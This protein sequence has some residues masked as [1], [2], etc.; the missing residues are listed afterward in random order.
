M[1]K[2]SG[3][4][5]AVLRRTELDHRLTSA[6]ISAAAPEAARVEHEPGGNPSA[7][8]RG[9][10]RHCAARAGSR[11]SSPSLRRST[12]GIGIVGAPPRPEW[13]GDL[14]VGGPGVDFRRGAGIA[15]G[16][17]VAE[18]ACLVASER[19]RRWDVVVDHTGHRRGRPNPP[20]GRPKMPSSRGRQADGHPLFLDGRRPRRSVA[21][22]PI[23][24]APPSDLAAPPAFAGCRGAKKKK[25]FT[26]SQATRL[27]LQRRR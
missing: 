15:D 24:G 1:G 25:S 27:L 3:T 12:S 22:P 26:F 2:H 20:L 13:V 4:G 18:L 23:R 8:G 10:I 14:E 21:A 7:R 17:N 5:S 16:R 9:T 19:H 11:A 6:G